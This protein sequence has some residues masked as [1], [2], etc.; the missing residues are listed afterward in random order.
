[1]ANFCRSSLAELKGPSARCK[2]KPEGLHGQRE[3]LHSAASTNQ[4]LAGKQ[5]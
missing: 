2:A 5:H 3:D 4:S 1:M